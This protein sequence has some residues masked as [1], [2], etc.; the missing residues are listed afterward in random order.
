MGTIAAAA[1]HFEITATLDWQI[2]RRRVLI[3]AA[4]GHARA[5]G[6]NKAS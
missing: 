6:S 1:L 5:R 2:F 4:L 3:V